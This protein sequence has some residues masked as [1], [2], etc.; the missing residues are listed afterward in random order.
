MDKIRFFLDSG[1]FSGDSQ[2]KPVSLRDYI[3]FIQEHKEH[4]AIY[5]C[6]DVIGNDIETWE[7]QKIMEDEGLTPMPVF[8]VEDNVKYLHKCLE[9]DY[10]CLGGMAGGASP[11][12]RQHFLNDCFRIICDTEDR[13]PRS[14]VHGFGLASPSLMTAYPFYSVDTSSWV[15]YSRFGIV[16]VPQQDVKGI[17][18]YEKTPIKIFVTERSPKKATEGLHYKNLTA[19]E[20]AAVLKYLKLS[21]FQ[22]G[23]STTFNATPDFQLGETETFM[24]K[25]KTIVERAEICGVSNSNAMRLSANMN[26]FQKIGESCPDYPWAW[27]TKIRSFF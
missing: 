6:L 14:K 26:Y 27:K 22:M 7:N 21:G 17:Y 19:S 1:A 11:N 25:E 23:R 4:I 3:D 9:Y 18:R 24:N 10:F 13:M 20:K 12:T 8:H 16:L 5:P 15:A 2:N